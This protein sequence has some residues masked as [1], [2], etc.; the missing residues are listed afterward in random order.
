M[1]LIVDESSNATYP[2]PPG[3]YARASP[4]VSA[5]ALPTSSRISSHV[6]QTTSFAYS[7]RRPTL[8]TRQHRF[9]TL[10]P[11]AAAHAS[12]ASA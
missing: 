6:A 10:A 3:A 9:T 5:S 7:T 11:L 1:S 12:R 8:A 4:N 2:N